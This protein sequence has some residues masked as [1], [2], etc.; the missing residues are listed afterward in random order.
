[1]ADLFGVQAEYIHGQPLVRKKHGL[2]LRRI[3][4]EFADGPQTEIQKTKIDM[5]SN[6]QGFAQRVM[7]IMERYDLRDFECLLGH[8][9]KEILRL[10]CEPAD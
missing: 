6:G 10:R 7:D 4:R 5:V 9:V 3:I 8:N 2:H 1:V